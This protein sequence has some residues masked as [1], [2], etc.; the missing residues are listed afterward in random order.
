VLLSWWVGV[1]VTPTVTGQGR[2]RCK[3]RFDEKREMEPHIRSMCL[4]NGR[5][6]QQAPVEVAAEAVLQPDSAER[7]MTEVV[8]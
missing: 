4:A 5:P 6:C 7:L 2:T 3:R 1:L 8:A